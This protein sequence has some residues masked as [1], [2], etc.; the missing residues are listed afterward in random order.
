MHPSA[1]VLRTYPAYADPATE[2]L[3]ELVD[4]TDCGPFPG[5]RGD[6]RI[7]DEAARRARRGGALR[8]RLDGDAS[9]LAPAASGRSAIS[10]SFRVG[11]D[12]S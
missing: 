2:S 6:E 12:V 9:V 7:L 5:D 11:P 1:T 8:L 10:A 4:A 3:S